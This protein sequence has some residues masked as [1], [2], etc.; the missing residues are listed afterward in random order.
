MQLPRPGR[1]IGKGRIFLSPSL[2]I[3]G[4]LEK[5]AK[6]GLGGVPMSPRFTLAMSAMR[7][8]VT[9]ML[10]PTPQGTMESHWRNHPE[11]TS[12]VAMVLWESQERLTTR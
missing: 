4:G 10:K 8:A 1:Y 6:K 5:V 9:T 11:L 3:G 12:S 2:G 7:T